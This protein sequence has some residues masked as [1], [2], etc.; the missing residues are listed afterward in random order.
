MLPPHSSPKSIFFSNLQAELQE[1]KESAAFPK[2][3]DLARSLQAL[4][5]ISPSGL[6]W[7]TVVMEPEFLLLKN[8]A[9]KEGHNPH[10][11]KCLIF[12]KSDFHPGK[13]TNLLKMPRPEVQGEPQIAQHKARWTQMHW[14]SQK[15]TTKW[16]YG[17]RHRLTGG[18]AG[19]QFS[20]YAIPA[21]QPCWEDA[22]GCSCTKQRGAKPACPACVP[23]LHSILLRCTKVQ[24]GPRICV[25]PQ[26][27]SCMKAAVNISL[28]YPHACYMCSSTLW[29]I[30]DP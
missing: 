30:K 27:V 1:L 26:V 9:Y 15:N 14:C 8:Q 24:Q 25:L 10:A 7:F 20:I 18:R 5:F 23:G 29:K 19:K 17:G 21:L 12:T 16:L 28:T 11:C 13:K 6:S 3:W 4:K 22:E 2:H